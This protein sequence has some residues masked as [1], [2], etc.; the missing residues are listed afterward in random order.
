LRRLV[1][2]VSALSV[3][4]LAAAA[5]AAT[6]PYT[7]SIAFTSKKA[8]TT[9]EPAPVGYTQVV[10][11]TTPSGTRPPVQLEITLKIYGLKVDGKDFPTCS[12]S[13]IAAAHNDNVCPPK[14]K[15]ASGYIRS[16][17]GS[18]TDFSQPGNDCDPA[19]DVWNS[20]QGKET[21]FFVTD[22]THQCL[23]G[24]LKTGSTPP[25][26][27]TYKQVG[28]YFVGDVKVPKYIDYPTQGLVG[29]LQVEHLFFSTQTA[30][31]HGKTVVS[32]GSIGC[33]KGKRPYSITTVTTGGSEGSQKV[34]K[35]ISASA[36]C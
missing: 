7:G 28:K 19:L 22:A 4:G 24:A 23:G 8:G 5:Y 15:I 30:K 17:L 21:Y 13:K 16:L 20:G 2:I 11:T 9:S 31:V 25:Y 12:L 29:S 10:K 32:S 18:A 1:I 6:A 26:P 35:T 3:L 14:A 27:G 33:L 34:T 36:P